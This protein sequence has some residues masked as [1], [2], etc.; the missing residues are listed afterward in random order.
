MRIG[1]L[2]N[3]L[4][5]NMEIIFITGLLIFEKPNYDKIFVAIH[6]R[7]EYSTRKRLIKLDDF[8]SRN[9]KNV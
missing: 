7:A 1:L 5:F 9:L 3:R 6:V 2:Q 4:L 8:Q